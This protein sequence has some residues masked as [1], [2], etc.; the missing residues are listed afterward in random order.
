MRLFQVRICSMGMLVE[1]LHSSA[2]EARASSLM[3]LELAWD[4]P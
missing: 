2:G 4:T 1:S 3:L